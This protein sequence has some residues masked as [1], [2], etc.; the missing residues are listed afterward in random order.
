MEPSRDQELN[1]LRPDSISLR[2]NSSI[3]PRSTY[4]RVPSLD[5][6]ID[7]DIS[8]Q[9]PFHN[10]PPQLPEI[11]DLG[12]TS[13]V[14]LGI[15]DTEGPLLQNESIHSRRSRP[16]SDPFGD[17]P[18]SARES[19]ELNEGLERSRDQD[20]HLSESGSHIGSPSIVVTPGEEPNGRT[21]TGA[22]PSH[23]A[24]YVVYL[25]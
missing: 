25:A 3:H 15:L 19:I 9:T 8:R 10:G 12:Q 22:W 23:H 2:P 13:S 5:G 16:L 24:V 1:L 18:N 21:F 6:D 11:S 7:N 4:R 14:G 17:G 20:Y